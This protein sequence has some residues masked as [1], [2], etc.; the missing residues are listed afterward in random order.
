MKQA[1]ALG[2]EVENKKLPKSSSWTMLD[3]RTQLKFSNFFE[4]KSGMIDPRCEQFYSWIK[5]GFPFQYVHF[6]NAGEN[7]KFQSQCQSK[8]WTFNLVFKITGRDTPQRNH[9]AELGFAIIANRV[10]TLMVHANVPKDVCYQ[11]LPQKL[12][13]VALEHYHS[14]YCKNQQGQMM[15]TMFSLP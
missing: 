5:D 14:P 15:F 10:R 9:S 13:I 11:V 2:E 6:D 4:T 7:V 3:V 1:V 12:C 8:L